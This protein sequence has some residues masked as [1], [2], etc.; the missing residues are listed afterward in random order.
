MTDGRALSL[1]IPAVVVYVS[2]GQLFL[3]TGIRSEVVNVLRRAT[4]PWPVKES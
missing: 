1:L 4:K 2:I 3:G